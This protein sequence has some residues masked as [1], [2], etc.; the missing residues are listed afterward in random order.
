[1]LPRRIHPVAHSYNN[2]QCA[3][4]TAIPVKSNSAC[5]VRGL[6]GCKT[7]K[8]L[9]LSDKI[10]ARV[11]DVLLHRALGTSHRRLFAIP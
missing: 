3:L 10:L 9:F 8:T 1:M 7:L 5:Q 11:V 4:V 6:E 2:D